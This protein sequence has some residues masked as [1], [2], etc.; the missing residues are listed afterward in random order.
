MRLTKNNFVFISSP[1]H[2]PRVHPFFFKLSFLFYPSLFHLLLKYFAIG[3]EFVLFLGT[4]SQNELCT[5]MDVAP[6]SE[7]ENAPP[8]NTTQLVATIKACLIIS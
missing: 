8:K 2:S 3:W 7:D 1:L 5:W 6:L 4:N